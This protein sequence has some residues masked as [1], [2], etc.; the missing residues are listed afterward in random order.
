M[1]S[2]ERRQRE[3]QEVQEK[4]LTAARELFVAH[5]FEAVSLR[6]VADAIDYTPPALYTHF[7]DKA[8]LLRALCVQDF[9]AL[10]DAL[11]RASKVHDPV[12]R[13]VRI[14]QAY[15]RFAVEH[16]HHYKFMFMTPHPPEVE[17][18]PEAFKHRDDPERDGYAALR[19]GCAEAIKLGKFL[20]QYK[21][22]ELMAQVFWAGVHG[23]ASL[24]IAMGKDPWINWCSIERRSRAMTEALVRGMLTPEAIKEFER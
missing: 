10:S 17:P 22:P 5:G 3:R 8:D 20:P 16:P 23:I 12:Q 21:D 6:K 11:L 4:I 15:I 18:D 24:E 7:K 2:A 1:S 13:L 19:H 14:G 9:G